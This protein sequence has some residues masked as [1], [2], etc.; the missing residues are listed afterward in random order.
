MAGLSG[1]P[2]LNRLNSQQSVNNNHRSVEESEGAGG[3]S[4]G[5]SLGRSK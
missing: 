3:L 4:G 1:A 5:V 2:N